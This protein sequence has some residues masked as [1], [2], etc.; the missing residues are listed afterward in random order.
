M[1]KV[2][3]LDRDGTINVEKKYVYKIED[4]EYIDG[5]LEALTIL[6]NQGYNLIIITNQSGIARNF[7]TERNYHDLTK[8]MLKDMQ[9]K[10]INILD[11]YY[12]PH[13]KQSIDSRYAIDCNCR[14]PRTG[15]FMRAINEHYIDLKNSYA[16]G[17]QVRDLQ[18]C[19]KT[20]IKGILLSEQDTYEKKEYISIYKKKIFVKSNLLEA[21]MFIAQTNCEGLNYD[22]ERKS[23]L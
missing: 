22:L 11:T 18:I 6:Q 9:E 20:Q 12:C 15:L 8:W 17:D 1:K 7:Y 16:I 5:S 13:L 2:V 23:D 4:F 3:F 14:K 10:G 21:A 19:F